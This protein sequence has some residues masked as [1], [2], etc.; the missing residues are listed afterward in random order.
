MFL[1]FKPSTSAIRQFLEMQD[2]KP[3]SY[4]EVGITRSETASSSFVRDHN[5]I[6]L[7]IGN[8]VF[9]QAKTAVRNWKMF[10][11]PWIELCF[12]STPIEAGRT[13]AILVR[14][15]RFY[16]LNAARI[17]YVIDEPGRFGFAYGTLPEHGEIGEERFSV[18]IDQT[19]GEVRYDLLAYSRPGALL[20]KI[21]YPLSRYL[22]KSFATDSKQAMK[23]AVRFFEKNP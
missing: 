21:G 22:Q 7:G 19:T 16:S 4:R 13:V 6:L 12:A 20:A 5:R 1:I 17:A 15:F 8:D 10:A 9:E 14:H 3:F 18:E 23:N 2:G 11:F